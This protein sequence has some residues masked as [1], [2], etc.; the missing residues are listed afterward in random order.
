M[1]EELDRYYYRLDQR[2][3]LY[4]LEDLEADGR[5]FGQPPA[6]ILDEVAHMMIE[7][8]SNAATDY[9]HM[10]LGQETI[11][12]TARELG[13]QSQT[14]PCPF[15]GQFLIMD[16]HTRPQIDGQT[17]LEFYA[18]DPQRYGEELMQL[19][20]AFSEDAQFH[21]EAFDWRRNTRRPDI[22]TQRLFS[23][24][25]NSRG[26]AV[27]Y[28]DL[29][30]RLSL[31]GLDSAESSFI[32]RRHLEWPMRYSENQE[33]FTNLAYKGGA[34]PGILTTVYYAYPIG[35]TNPVVVALFYHD[36]HNSIYQRWRRSLAH[37]EFA[38]WLLY[39]PQAIPAMRALI[40]S[41]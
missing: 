5:I 3:H 24:Q 9:L 39:E 26:T 6:L 41:G 27:E 20:A 33:L 34:L 2:A 15:V 19:T 37:D 1:L 29:M 12:E 25:F 13:L 30:A 32:T 22:G 38:R 35:E 4:A 14:A 18:D 16:N 11:E 21:E 8:S 7:Y 23:E 31:N 28:E 36:L 40:E 17:A 10:R